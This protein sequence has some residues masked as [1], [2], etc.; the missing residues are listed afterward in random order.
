MKAILLAACV[1]ALPAQVLAASPFDGTWKIDVGTMQAPSKPS[2]FLLKD[3]MY[4]CESCVPRFT[5]KADGIAH[6]IAGDP[7]A[8]SVLIRIV[9]THTVE[10]TDS[11]AGKPIFVLTMAVS[12]DSKT[13]TTSLIDNSGN[14]KAKGTIIRTRLAAAP[15]GSHVVSGEWRSTKY[16]G[17]SDNTITVTLK[18]DGDTFSFSQP[19]G[20]SY[21]ATLGGPAAPYTGDPGITTVSAA[22][23]GADTIVETD[24]RGDKA[25]STN[26]MTTHDGKTLELTFVDMLRG[27]TQH[28][29]ATHQ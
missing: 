5:V 12:A 22:R 24:M 6:P 16:E 8:D 17:Y 23:S 11:K 27:S 10:E 20:Q 9:D 28:F 14:A 25:I 1:A 2:V 18:L 15:P 4:S 7:Y 26:T 19:T 29:T 21:T 3:G 13:M